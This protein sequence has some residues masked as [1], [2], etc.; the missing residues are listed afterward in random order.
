M[1]RPSGLF[2]R[3]RARIETS[4]VLTVDRSA[5]PSG[6]S[7]FTSV[8]C[9]YQS[10]QPFCQV[11]ICQRAMVHR[12]RRELV[13][14]A[15]SSGSTVIVCMCIVAMVTAVPRT[16]VMTIGAAI[17]DIP[18]RA[19]V[20]TTVCTDRCDPESTQQDGERQQTPHQSE[21]RNKLAY[22][23]HNTPPVSR[24]GPAG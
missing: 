8:P 7:A 14:E 11:A 13:A 10:R 5:H 23:F 22:L 17:L 6:K 21:A 18:A 20:F 9:A 24:T 12:D 15:G 4:L 1:Q 3:V 2:G 19:K 16:A